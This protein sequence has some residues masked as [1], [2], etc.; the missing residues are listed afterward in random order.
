MMWP[1]RPERRPRGRGSMAAKLAIGV[2]AAVGL[3]G[4]SASSSGGVA[5]V[6]T[7]LTAAVIADGI[8]AR[9]AASAKGHRT[10]SPMM[11]ATPASK[12]V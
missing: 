10:R 3:A 12:I 8:A 11:F 5:T 1:S 9:D 7:M 6:E 2:G 4:Y